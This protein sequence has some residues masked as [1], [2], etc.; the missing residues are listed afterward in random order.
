MRLYHRSKDDKINGIN[1]SFFDAQH[2]RV[3]LAI[4]RLHDLD[5]EFPKDAQIIYAEGL[6]RKDYLGQGIAARMLFEKAYNLD[7][8]HTFAACNA[9]K[10]A[11]DEQEFRKWAEISLRLVSQ[12]DPTRQVMNSILSNLDSGIR[13]W[14]LLANGSQDYF[15]TNIFGDSAALMELALLAGEM[16]PDEEVMARRGR[17]QCLRALDAEAHQSHETIMES[18]PPE[19]RLALHEALAE[20]DKAIFL[21]EYDSEI[22]NLKSA[23]CY[24]LGRHEEAIQCADMA[25]RQ[26]PFNYPKPYINKAG[27]FWELR[28]DSDALVC[29]QEALKQAENC[30]STADIT[31]ARKMIEDYS[32]PRIAPD[33]SNIEPII[34]H[35]L[36]AAQ[37]TMDLEIGQWRGSVERLVDGVLK[38]AASVGNDWTMDYVLIMAELLS[39]FTP[40]TAFCVIL[41]TAERSQKVHEH[42]LHAA[43]YVA[44]HSDGVR[45]REAVR[46][47]V[48]SIFGAVDGTSIRRTY[49]QAILETSS[50]ATDGMSRLDAIMREELRCINPVFPK[51]IADQDP[52]DEHGRERAIRT[53]LSRFTGDPLQLTQ[54]QCR[55]GSWVI[56]VIALVILLILF[57]II[58]G[59]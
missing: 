57:I 39:D 27:A 51:L 42:C 26:R 41:K 36:N 16:H 10:F 40:E 37:I 23:W 17:S 55:R 43:L 9:T 47:L 32:T 3:R 34:R 12:D 14:E 44:A 11:R 21:D 1:R 35:I 30:H 46:F 52:V 25:I 8:R 15:E 19:E 20:L 28:R 53:I 4:E 31:Q 59:K 56:V 6:I 33:I 18:F 24:L 58:Y 50:A 22:W 54:W 2:G 7:N 45:Q 5:D 38:R 48:L 13:Y 29:A 49:R